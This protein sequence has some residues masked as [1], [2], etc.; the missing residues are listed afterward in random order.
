VNP[1]LILGDLHL[2]E[3][4]SPSHV[5]GL[6]IGVDKMLAPFRETAKTRTSLPYTLRRPSDTGRLRWSNSPFHTNPTLCGLVLT[7]YRY[8][9]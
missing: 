4:S 2:T 6:W 7:V 9:R 1:A 8:S 3:R 5:V